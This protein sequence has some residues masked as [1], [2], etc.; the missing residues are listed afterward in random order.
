METVRNGRILIYL[1]EGVNRIC[2]WFGCVIGSRVKDATKVFGL[3]GWKDGVVISWDGWRVRLLWACWVWDLSLIELKESG[4]NERFNESCKFG[5]HQHYRWYL[6]SCDWMRSPRKSVGIQNRNKDWALGLSNF[7]SEERTKAATE[8]KREPL[9][10]P[11]RS[12]TSLMF[13]WKMH[14]YFTLTIRKY[15]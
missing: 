13:H 6:K 5:S 9:Q 4:V 10:I 1:E 15:R 12:Y 3:S 2:W 7:K 8:V 14:S 11:I